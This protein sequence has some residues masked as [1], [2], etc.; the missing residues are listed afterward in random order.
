MFNNGIV[1][2]LLDMSAMFFASE[3]VPP[4]TER[5]SVT[6]RTQFDYHHE[7]YCVAIPSHHV[8]MVVISSQLSPVQEVCG[9]PDGGGAPVE[10][11][12]FVDVEVM[13]VLIGYGVS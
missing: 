4:A 3:A 13:V 9:S 10:E 7:K 2:G 1:L 11:S 5:G 6:T 8:G 12:A